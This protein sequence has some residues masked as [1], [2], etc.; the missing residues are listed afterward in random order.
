MEREYRAYT[1]S[2]QYY[3]SDGVL[4]FDSAIVLS[5]L[6]NAK[7]MVER[8]TGGI[9]RMDPAGNCYRQDETY[10]HTLSDGE[11]RWSGFDPTYGTPYWSWYTLSKERSQM[12]WRN[13]QSIHRGCALFDRLNHTV[14]YLPMGCELKANQVS[15]DS[16]FRI[17][18]YRK[19]SPQSFSGYC[20]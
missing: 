16:I 2:H 5:D 6:L 7:I 19:E 9:F 10:K 12:T 14:D 20:E 18:I 1:G 8:D 13:Y 15:L 3:F 4:E 11:V 17:D